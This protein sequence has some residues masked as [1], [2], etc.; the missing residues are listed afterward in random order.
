MH[1]GPS[2]TACRARTLAHDAAIPAGEKIFNGIRTH[3]ARFLHA[4]VSGGWRDAAKGELLF[5]GG[6]D[7]TVFEEGVAPGAPMAHMGAK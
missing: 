5:I 1:P 4:P 7:K 6:G 3:G 2:R